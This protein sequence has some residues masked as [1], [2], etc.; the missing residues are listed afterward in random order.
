MPL[1]LVLE[2]GG[3][4]EHIPIVWSVQCVGGGENHGQ[5]SQ[6]SD[7]CRRGDPGNQEV[8]QLGQPVGLLAMIVQHVPR[9]R[10]ARK[11]VC[12]DG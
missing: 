4:G 3:A 6:S 1:E 12:L 10:G 7:R 9:S 5:R 2:L 11:L 8:V